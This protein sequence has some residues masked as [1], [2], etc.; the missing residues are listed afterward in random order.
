MHTDCTILGDKGS[1]IVD[2]KR[3]LFS[4]SQIRLEVS[5]R[6]NQHGYKPLA[7]IFRKSR[8]RIEAL[9][10]QLYDLFLIRRI[11]NHEYRY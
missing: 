10:S 2:Y 4:S 11:E 9:F 7:Y 5:M 6:R 8:K 1:L 3:D